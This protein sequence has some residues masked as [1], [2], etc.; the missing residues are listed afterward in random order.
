MDVWAG[1]YG[2]RAAFICVSCAGSGLAEQFGNELRLSKCTLTYA[3]QGPRWGQLGCS[4]FIVL[5]GTQRVV[6]AASSAYLEVRDLAFKHVEALLDALLEPD[7][8]LPAVCPGQFVRLRGLS[9]AELNGQRGVCVSAPGDEGRLGVQLLRGG[10]QVSVKL[11]NVRRET[12]EGELIE[13]IEPPQPNDGFDEGDSCARRPKQPKAQPSAPPQPAATEA[14]AAGGTAA[15]AQLPSV[16]VPQLD[17]EHEACAAALRELIASPTRAALEAVASA[18][19]VHFGHEEAM[20]DEF[21]YGA[22]PQAAGGGFDLDR[23]QRS[24]HWADHK[25]Q[26]DVLHKE[27]I[28]LENRCGHDQVPTAAVEEIVRDFEQHAV[29]YDSYGERLAAAIAAVH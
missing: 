26:L 14:P 10:K 21:L 8:A 6:C 17:A 29:R 24:S 3:E 2:S 16:Q 13:D 11:A 4:G 15:L 20:L 18:F 19:T 5:D 27:M 23:N 12:A 1:R 7:A 28:A 9:K 22:Q 25:R